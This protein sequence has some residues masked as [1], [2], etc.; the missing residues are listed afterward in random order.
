M[1]GLCNALLPGADCYRMIANLNLIAQL[2]MIAGLWTGFY[3]ART[4]QINKHMNMQTTVVIANIFFI[5]FIMLANFSAFLKPSGSPLSQLAM[6]H[7]SL[8]L[9]AEI[10]G[11]Y[12][13][14]RMRTNWIPKN[15]RVK[16]FKLV[17][18]ATIGLWTLIIALG[19]GIYYLG[20]IS[21]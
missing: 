17:M 4:R 14:L 11:I 2:L 10:T 16:N 8:G 6:I 19:L 15:L 5:A 13:V 1:V 21:A 9:I 18:R 7:G 3:F 20:Y 12:L